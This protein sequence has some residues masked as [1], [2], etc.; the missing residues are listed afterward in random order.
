MPESP[1]RR[2]RT[3]QHPPSHSHT[4]ILRAPSARS[5]WTQELGTRLMFQRP[6]DPNAYLLQVLKDMKAARDS[7]TPVRTP[8][9]RCSTHTPF[10]PDGNEAR[11]SLG[12]ILTECLH[13]PRFQTTFFTEQDVNAMFELFD[14]TGR[15]YI[16]KDQYMN[17]TFDAGWSCGIFGGAAR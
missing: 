16:S 15:G 4:L 6:K 13:W 14:P 1:A 2:P 8:H 11:R 10:P 9:P 17:G 3:H 12:G 7:K 5:S